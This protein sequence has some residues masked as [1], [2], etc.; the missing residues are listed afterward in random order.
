MTDNILMSSIPLKNDAQSNGT[1]KNNTFSPEISISEPVI[2]NTNSSFHSMKKEKVHSKQINSYTTW[3]KIYL[4]ATLI[5]LMCMIAIILQIPTVLYY[6]D[7]PS[8]EP[9]LLDNINLE[10]CS[11]SCLWHT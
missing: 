7:P 5:I 1:F 10:T 3:E 9:V 4:P 8:A 6:S 11:V 2:D